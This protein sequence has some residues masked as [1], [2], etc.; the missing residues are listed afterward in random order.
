MNTLTIFNNTY[1]RMVFP[2]PAETDCQSVIIGK[3]E[4]KDQLTDSVTPQNPHIIISPAEE[5][6]GF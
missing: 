4:S 2:A 6:R 5:F 3:S 1:A